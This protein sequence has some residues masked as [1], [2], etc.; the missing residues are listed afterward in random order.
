M[1]TTVAPLMAI[2]VRKP[3]RNTNPE[4]AQLH[5]TEWHGASISSLCSIFLRMKES[6]VAPK[7]SSSATRFQTKF[8]PHRVVQAGVSQFTL[9]VGRKKKR[10]SPGWMLAL[11]P[12]ACMVFSCSNKTH[13][14]KGR[15]GGQ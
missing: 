13:G 6:Q 5:N 11:F 3:S 8:A 4:P 15:C 9:S 14:K 2:A 1:P 7:D 10:A 12:V